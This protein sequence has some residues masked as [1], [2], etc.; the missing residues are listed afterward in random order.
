M[1]E[2]EDGNTVYVDFES[3]RKHDGYVYFWR[4]AD[5]LKPSEHGTL[6]AKLYI[7]GDC[8]KFR[9]NI[10]SW[11]WHKEP[12]GGGI[13]KTLNTPDKE[14]IYPPPDSSVETI[15]KS[16]CQYADQHKKW[17]ESLKKWWE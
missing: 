15:L 3:I 10:L 6:S 8:K 13:S 11:S 12:M 1:D 2:F 7:Q 17:W 14:W 9:L 4:L 16:V 5:F